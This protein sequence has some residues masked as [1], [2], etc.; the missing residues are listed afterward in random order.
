METLSASPAS[1][2]IHTCMDY[3]LTTKKLTFQL[4][5]KFPDLSQQDAEDLT[6][7]VYLK[8]LSTQVKFIDAIRWD[9]LIYI[10]AINKAMNQARNKA[11]QKRRKEELKWNAISMVEP[12][13][14]VKIRMQEDSKLVRAFMSILTPLELQ[15][16]TCLFF[17]NLTNKDTAQLLNLRVTTIKSCRQRSIQRMRNF[18]KEQQLINFTNCRVAG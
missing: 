11:V 7:D 1:A 6:Q 10:S 3:T 15:V 9:G 17:M 4:L 8:L 5:S 13:A 14:E 16:V 2:C 18:A 12:E